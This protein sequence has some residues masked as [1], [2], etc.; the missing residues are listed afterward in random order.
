MK[1]IKVISY[2][3][4]FKKWEYNISDHSLHRVVDEAAIEREFNLLLDESN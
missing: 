4:V 2:F 3:A 1:I